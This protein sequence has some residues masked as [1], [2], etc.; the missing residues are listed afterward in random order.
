MRPRKANRLAAAESPYLRQHGYDPVDWYPWGQEAFQKAKA[1]DKPIFLSIGYATCHWCHVMAR[2]SFS[3]PQVASFLNQHFVSIKV[4]R[5]ELPQVDE[6][7]MRAAMALGGHSG[8]PLSVFCTP[9][10]LP[11]YAGTYFPPKPRGGLPS[12]QQVLESVVAV[13]ET[14]RFELEEQRDGLLSLLVP[15]SPAPGNLDLA[16]LKSEALARLEAEFDQ[17]N[18]GFGGAPKF[19]LPAQLGFLLHLARQANAKAQLMLTKSL[20]GMAQGGIRDALFGGFHRYS[21]DERWFIPHYEKMLPDNALLAQLYLEAGHLFRVTR[22]REV[23]RK[24]LHFI[25]SLFRQGESLMAWAPADL[26]EVPHPFF[27]AGWDADTHGEEGKTFIFSLPELAEAL[28]PGQLELV[29]RL[30]P[31]PWSDSPRPLALRPLD[32]EVARQLR[33]PWPEAKKEL[34]GALARLNRVAQGKGLPA[35]DTQAVSAWNAMAVGAFCRFLQQQKP[36]QALL[37]PVDEML[38][39]PLED[40]DEEELSGVPSPDRA[41]S[42]SLAFARYISRDTYPLS[43]AEALWQ[44]R[45]P[46]PGSIPR[47]IVKGCPHSPETLEDLAWAAWAFLEVFLTTGASFW[48]ARVARLLERRVPHY[49]GAQGEL[50]TTPDDQSVFPI[51][52]RNPYD[53]AHPNPAAVLCRTLYRLFWLTG[54]ETFR[55]WA[56][57]ALAAEAQFVAASPHNATSWLLAG[58]EGQ[59]TSVLV[60]AGSPRWASTQALIRTAH[61]HPHKPHM[62]I[63]LDRWPPSRQELFWLPVFQNRPA[64]GE[65]QAQAYLCR[66]SECLPPVTSPRELRRLLTETAGT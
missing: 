11:F 56:D 20:E 57:E 39:A 61:R 8:W 14:R 46:K 12:F 55:T 54:N 7:Y 3:D 25:R 18:G 34:T 1:E 24:T 19:P 33:L 36:G 31:F 26:A 27:V 6:V 52:Q 30:S 37:F 23:G 48:L 35:V 40:E 43:A 66:G 50:F 42:A 58:E 38:S 10:G 64:A 32:A 17:E 29:Q 4:D 21:T 13:W 47:T 60:V 65:E 15:P 44:F 22:W 5:Q 2:E 41:W 16:A 59:K 45:W 53:G 49:R 63:F 28:T 51:R 9:E 62:V